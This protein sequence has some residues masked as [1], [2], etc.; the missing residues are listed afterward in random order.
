MARLV[1]GDQAFFVGSEH[2]RPA[3]PK[4]GSLDRLVEILAGDRG[5]A[6][7]GGDQRGLVDDVAQVGPDEAG[8]RAGNVAE[9]DVGSERDIACVD[10]EDRLAPRLVRCVDCHPTI[11]S[12]GTE[13]GGIEDFGTVGRGQHDHVLGGREAIHLGQDLV[14]GLL[15]F[16][17]CAEGR[18]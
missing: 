13:Q 16:V 5:P 3:K 14:E 4:H 6:L 1:I 9:V 17:V 8:R 10:L 15:A 7:A 2:D 12:A 18:G 11:K